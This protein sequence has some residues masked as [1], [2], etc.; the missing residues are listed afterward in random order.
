MNINDSG[1]PSKELAASDKNGESG[2]EEMEEIT[3]QRAPGRSTGL[4]IEERSSVT[5]IPGRQRRPPRYLQVYDELRLHR[6]FLISI[7]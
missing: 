2:E 7:I 3:E 5:Q 6:S 1:Q 4:G